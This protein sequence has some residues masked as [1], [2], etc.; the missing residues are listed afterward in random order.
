[1]NIYNNFLRFTLLALLFSIPSYATEDPEKYKFEYFD[2]DKSNDLSS[3]EIA[4]IYNHHSNAID[5]A[6]NSHSLKSMNHYYYFLFYFRK[7][8]K[9][10]YQLSPTEQAL[11]YSLMTCYKK[12]YCND[13]YLKDVKLSKEHFFVFINSLNSL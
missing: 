13:R 3:N 5:E 9:L 4:N 1:M 10:S 12:K 7:K 8:I 6:I 2:T 11:A